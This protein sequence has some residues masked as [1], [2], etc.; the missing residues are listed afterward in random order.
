VGESSPRVRIPPSPLMLHWRCVYI[1]V[2]LFWPLSSVLCLNW[3][4]AR[5]NST[6]RNDA[7]EMGLA[8]PSGIL[9]VFDSEKREFGEGVAQ[10]VRWHILLRALRKAADSTYPWEE[11]GVRLAQACTAGLLLR[12]AAKGFA[13]INK[14]TDEQIAG[15]IR[16]GQALAAWNCHFEAARGGMYG[17]SR[18]QF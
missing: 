1:A 10:N 9:I 14:S 8:T 11:S 7:M 4:L 3:K 17:V 18:K 16:F 5:S 2:A 15:A 13:K 12:I 6:N